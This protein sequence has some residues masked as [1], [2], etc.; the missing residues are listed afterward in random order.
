MI[1]PPPSHYGSGQ[2]LWEFLRPVPPAGDAPH[3]P[4][5]APVGEGGVYWPQE[6]VQDCGHHHTPGWESG[7][8]GRAHLPSLWAPRQE[9]VRVWGHP[10]LVT[11]GH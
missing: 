10:L 11:S 6:R 7:E 1:P 5:W 3:R 2:G 8:V 4:S 9:F